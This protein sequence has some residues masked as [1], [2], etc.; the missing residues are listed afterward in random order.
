MVT[1]NCTFINN[2]VSM[3]AEY[4][5]TSG[6]ESVHSGHYVWA[7]LFLLMLA[8]IPVVLILNRFR[9]KSKTDLMQEQS[10]EP[11]ISQDH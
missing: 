3:V 1:G 4:T 7:Q 11:R 2:A 5:V 8:V 9:R 10:H 6:A